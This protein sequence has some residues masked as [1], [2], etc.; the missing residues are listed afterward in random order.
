MFLKKHNNILEKG[1]NM[2]EQNNGPRNMKSTL[3]LLRTISLILIILGAVLLYVNKAVDFSALTAPFEAISQTHTPGAKGDSQVVEAAKDLQGT[4]GI[5]KAQRYY[6]NFKVFM[7]GVEQAVANLPN[8]F[9]VSIGILILFAIK[10]FIAIVPVSFT[11]LLAGA[12]FPLPVALF[13]NL[14][15]II[16]IFSIK[17]FMGL[18]ANKNQL[19]N[20]IKKSDF[21][22]KVVT[23]PSN[24]GEGNTLLLF[25]L[26]LLPSFPT[27]PISTFYGHRQYDFVKYLILSVVGYMMKLVTYTLLGYNIYDP[28]SSKLFLII[29]II[30]ILSGAILIIVSEVLRKLEKDKA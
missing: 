3:R 28:F 21:L 26:R 1:E 19:E 14:I 30:F 25:M 18:K 12:I 9:L 27:N 17:Y 16:E 10:A 29:G 22:W 4:L 20:L 15:G 7:E 5:T 2:A 8:K 24:G 6:I 23:D 11:C 13:L